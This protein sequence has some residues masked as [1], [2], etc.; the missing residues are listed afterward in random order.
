M[1]LFKRKHS[2]PRPV[3]PFRAASPERRLLLLREQ[4]T[5][6]T[7]AEAAPGAAHGPTGHTEGAAPSLPRQ[8]AP[9]G[10]TELLLRPR[11]GEAG[12]GALTRGS[13]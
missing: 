3:P 2:A 4:L 13:V 7:R 5:K 11:R 1:P 9:S 12:S 10:A 6:Q 8:P